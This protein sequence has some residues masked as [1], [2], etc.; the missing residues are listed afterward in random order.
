MERLQLQILQFSKMS[1]PQTNSR[2]K[3]IKFRYWIARRCNKLNYNI[4]YTDDE[5]MGNT[6]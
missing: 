3:I 4:S 6:V 2:P 5:R 1:S